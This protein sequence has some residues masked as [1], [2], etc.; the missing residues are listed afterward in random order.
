M[1]DSN[2]LSAFIFF[3]FYLW[4]QRK[5]YSSL[6]LNTIPLHTGTFKTSSF[7]G[8]F[9]IIN[10][11]TGTI[12]A[13]SA[14]PDDKGDAQESHIASSGCD[15]SRILDLANAA[16]GSHLACSSR[17]RSCEAVDAPISYTVFAT[18]P[19]PSSGGCGIP[20]HGDNRLSDGTRDG[21]PCEQWEKKVEMKRGCGGSRDT[22]LLSSA[23]IEEGRWSPPRL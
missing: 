13:D 9:A 6:T 19:V 21:A 2:A 4:H 8:L 1:L 18:P 14:L 7:V 17:G 16:R 11:Y 23:A 22:Q 20:R 10:R 5:P 12:K 15:L 3:C